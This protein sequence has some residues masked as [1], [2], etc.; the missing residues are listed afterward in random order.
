MSFFIRISLFGNYLI[1]YN[2]S[3]SDAFL[4]GSDPCNI[5]PSIF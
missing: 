4:G 1:S 5:S 3:S 2:Q